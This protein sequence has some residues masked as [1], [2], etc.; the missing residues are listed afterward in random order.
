VLVTDRLD[1]E[2][3]AVAAFAKAQGSPEIAVP[4]KILRV[5]QVPVLGTGK[6]DYVTIQRLAEEAA[7]EA[8]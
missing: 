7:Q 1:A 4:K 5:D 3:A 8:A 6:T 2:V